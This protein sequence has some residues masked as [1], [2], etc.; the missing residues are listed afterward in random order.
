MPG[1]VTLREADGGEDL[2][3]LVHKPGFGGWGTSF[4]EEESPRDVL[5]V[6]D[7]GGESRDRAGWG[8]GAANYDLDPFPELVT[9]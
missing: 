3:D 8:V 4:R 9:F 1:V 2:P 6:A 7:V 5:A